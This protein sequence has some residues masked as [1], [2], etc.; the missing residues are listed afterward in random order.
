MT[1]NNH[2]KKERCFL[3]YPFFFLAILSFIACQKQ[4]VLDFWE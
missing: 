1:K 4:P 3:L 2:L